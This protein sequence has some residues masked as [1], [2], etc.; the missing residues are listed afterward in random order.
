MVA[1][2]GNSLGGGTPVKAELNAPLSLR[3]LDWLTL[4]LKM[5]KELQEKG[6]PSFP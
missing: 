5:H 2:H 6:I 3:G 4:Y 1:G